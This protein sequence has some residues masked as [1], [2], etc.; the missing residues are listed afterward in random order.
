MPIPVCVLWKSGRVTGSANA[1]A[2]DIY[3]LLVTL[4]RA[5]ILLVVKS[6]NLLCESSYD[7]EGVAL[8]RG[9][10][11]LARIRNIVSILLLKGVGPTRVNLDND[12][13]RLVASRLGNPGLSR[14]TQ[15]RYVV[16]LRRVDDGEL[17]PVHQPDAEMMADFGT[18]WLPAA[19][20]RQSLRYA[21]NSVAWHGDIAAFAAWLPL[22]PV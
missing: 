3:C 21:S 22:R 16:V 10:Q 14:H 2:A 8:V 15:R 13:L 9:G 6:I 4:A 17:V 12:S 18:K 7:S 11:A 5:V 19:K 20:L 1:K